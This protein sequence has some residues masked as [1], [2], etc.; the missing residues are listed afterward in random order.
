MTE[1]RLRF[2]DKLARLFAIPHHRNGDTAS[3]RGPSTRLIVRKRTIKLAQDDN[4]NVEE[5]VQQ[6]LQPLSS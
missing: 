6:E 5:L 1:A 3:C 4:R 2:P